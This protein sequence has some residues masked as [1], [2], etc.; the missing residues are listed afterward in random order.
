MVNDGNAEFF[1]GREMAQLGKQIAKE[2]K[3]EVDLKYDKT[4]LTYESLLE[5]RDEIRRGLRKQ[6]KEFIKLG[7]DDDEI[8]FVVIE[9]AKTNGEKV[10][11]E[12][13]VIPLVFELRGSFLN[14]EAAP[15][16]IENSG[17]VLE[18]NTVFPV[19]NTGKRAG[20]L[21][22]KTAGYMEITDGTDKPVSLT[23]YNGNHL[24]ALEVREGEKPENA[25][26]R[27]GFTNINTPSGENR[28]IRVQ[29]GYAPRIIR[30]NNL[31]QIIPW[32]NGYLKT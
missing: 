21:K 31:S 12:E 19:R 18:V 5:K 3:V 9:D 15:T 4:D 2:R 26:S 7:K 29:Y 22:G 8:M 16:F 1:L 11:I 32:I 30:K 23:E 14:Q 24:P 17:N 13:Q 10:T 25:L 20:L 6:G 27:Q 28:T